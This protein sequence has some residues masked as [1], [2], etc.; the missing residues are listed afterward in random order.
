[1]LSLN[2][3][4]KI[5]W[6][7]RIKG[8]RDDGF[9]EIESLMQCISLCDTLTLEPAST[10]TLKTNTDIPEEDNL[11]HKAAILLQKETSTSAGAR[12]MLEKSIPM[13]AGLGGGSSDAAA[14]LKGLAEL[15]GL[16][17][18]DKKLMGLGAELGSDVPFFIG[19]SPAM[20][21]GRGEHVSPVAINKT[22]ELLLA[23]PP[24][25]VSARWAYRNLQLPSGPAIDFSSFIMALE[26][27]DMDAIPAYCLNDLEKPVLC[28]HAL[29]EQIKKALLE[30]GAFSALMSGSGTT[31][32]GV[33][34]KAEEADY[35]ATAMAK[36]FGPSLLTI[37][38]KTIP[39]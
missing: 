6:S 21:T 20:V 15:W 28:A 36:R 2:A 13:E 5:N 19:Q 10:I 16:D 7:L 24:F 39:S 33:F 35:A 26:N 29:L 11:I 22:Y 30:H 18:D 8:K 23:K 32:F 27:R 25:G 3:H 1:M 37:R 4:A 34:G 12:I 17:I 38:A 31:I 9:H 14:T